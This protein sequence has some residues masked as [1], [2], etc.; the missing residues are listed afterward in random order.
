MGLVPKISTYHSKIPDPALVHELDGH[1]Q[2]EVISFGEDG[3]ILT[4]SRSIY[5]G[6]Y[7]AILTGN[8]CILM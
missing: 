4:A 1:L 5:I 6:Q 3:W 7:P 8:P 2:R